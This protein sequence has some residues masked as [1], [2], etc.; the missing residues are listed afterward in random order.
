MLHRS[1]RPRQL[2]V[3]EEGPDL[4]A[5]A[6]FVDLEPGLVGLV[7]GLDLLPPEMVDLLAE[8]GELHG[9]GLVD[10]IG[11]DH[12]VGWQDLTP[13]GDSI[14]RRQLWKYDPLATF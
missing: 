5:E 12:P 14:V 1:P 2:L 7:K 9:E 8:C 11:R 13:H 3:L 10:R 6:G 4:F